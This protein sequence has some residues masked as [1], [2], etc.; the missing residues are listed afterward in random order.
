MVRLLRA[1]FLVL[2]AASFAG[3]GGGSSGTSGRTTVGPTVNTNGRIALTVLGGGATGVK[4]AW[5]TVD[6][7]AFNEDADKPW[8]PS[9]TSWKVITLTTPV[10]VDL[11]VTTP[12]YVLGSPTTGSILAVG[13]YKQIR[14]FFKAHDAA[15][16]KPGGRLYF[17]QVEYDNGDI[18]PIE[19][20]N[21]ASGVKLD[22]GVNIA[23]DELSSLY[24]R[25][26]AERNLVRFDGLKDGS[27]PSRE[28]MTI[29]PRTFTSLLVDPT[30]LGEVDS[31]WPRASYMGVALAPSRV[32]AAG[33]S[34]GPTCASNIYVSWHSPYA[35]VEQVG[36]VYSYANKTYSEKWGATQISTSTADALIGLLSYTYLT[37]S[38]GTLIRD[39]GGNPLFSNPTRY[40]MVIQ[41]SGMK[42]MVVKDVPVP[43]VVGELGCSRRVNYPN[44]YQNTQYKYI[45]GRIYPELVSSPRRYSLTS[46]LSPTSGRA[47]LAFK[48]SGAGSQSGMYYEIHSANTDPFTGQFTSG[49]RPS[50]PDRTLSSDVLVTTYETLSGACNA[51]IA[52]AEAEAQTQVN[53]ASRASDLVPAADLEI[54]LTQAAFALDT[55]TYGS[56]GLGTFYTNASTQAITLNDTD[57]A[58]APLTDATG[59]VSQSVDVTISGLSTVISGYGAGKRAYLVVSD[60]GGVVAT[61]DV[62]DC[63]DA[64]TRTVSLPAGTLAN[65]SAT[66]VYEFAVRYWDATSEALS[67]SV[68]EGGRM[69]WA[70]AA[71]F[72]NLRSG[73]VSPNP[74]VTIAVP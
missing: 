58:V 53:S 1:G 62:S 24:V 74:T 64:C 70:R 3:C 9:D 40:D 4:H 18:V 48:L 16:T 50:V 5:V 11:A 52:A 12:A 68:S 8:S 15:G 59:N 20:A 67:R 63:S 32:C 57:F 65:G 36:G 51:A 30:K 28:A 37:D 45:F 41:G 46:P 44:P 22:A 34:S 35:G 39:G 38:S 42:T 43:F 33:V 73:A 61:V 26:D 69:K 31:E 72:V 71:S 49:A 60:V 21:L 55:P 7:V 29:R 13:A 2:L 56:I 10:A 6:R 23:A 66:A 27:T 19:W 25:M 14:L 17:S 47:A 54:N